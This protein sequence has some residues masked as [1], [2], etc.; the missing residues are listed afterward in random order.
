M[1]QDAASC[2]T[3]SSGLRARVSLSP[4]TKHAGAEG[5]RVAAS[6]PRPI[7]CRSAKAHGSST[8]PAS[9]VTLIV[10]VRRGH[11]KHQHS[12]TIELF[13]HPSV[14]VPEDVC[15]CPCSTPPYGRDHEEEQT[16]T[17]TAAATHVG[18]VILCCS[19]RV[20]GDPPLLTIAFVVD[21]VRR[22]AV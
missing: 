5:M 11:A 22:R 18:T 16:S 19:A 6:R 3:G 2:L 20:R 1:K 4:L 8:S 21:G 12:R 7:E 17:L 14:T 9:P 15:A 13:A 10:W